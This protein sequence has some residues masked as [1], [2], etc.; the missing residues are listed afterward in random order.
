MENKYL[1]L[2]QVAKILSVTPQTLRNWDNSGKLKA[3][4]N[5]MNN[6]RIYKIETIRHLTRKIEQKRKLIF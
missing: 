3:L 6:Y 4:R 2:K 1:T 5:P